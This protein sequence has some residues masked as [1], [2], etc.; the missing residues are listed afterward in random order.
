MSC[1]RDGD[2]DTDT[3]LSLDPKE[4]H[5]TEQ[6]SVRINFTQYSKGS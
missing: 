3:L 1:V 4:F 2:H 6:Q 5:T